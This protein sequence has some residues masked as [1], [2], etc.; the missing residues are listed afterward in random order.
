MTRLVVVYD[1]GAAQPLEIHTGLAPLG[2]VTYALPHSDHND[3]MRPLLAEFGEVVPLDEDPAERI[4]RLRPDAVLTFSERQL[5]LTSDL[6][7]A[8]GLPGHSP[9]TARALTDKY[10]QRERLRAAGVDRLRCARLSGPGDWPAAV[11]AVG[12]PAVLK[13][14]RGEGSRDTHRI[15]DAAAGGRLVDELHRRGAADLVLERYLAGRDTGPYGD[16]VSVESV[17]THGRV[18]HVAVTGKYPLLEP[19][20]ERGQF[21]PAHLDHDESA[22]VADLAGRA[23]A[24]L[25]VRTGVAHTEIKLT[26]DGPHVIEVNGRLGGQLHDL[27]LR[28][29]GP[30]LVTLAGRAALGEALDIGPFRPDGVFFQHNNPAPVLACRLVAVRG[31]PQVRGM[32][33]IDGYR[34][35]VQPGAELPGGVM[36]R[37]LDVLTGRTADHGSML[38]LVAEARRALE[39]EF[40]MGGDTVR[41]R[42]DRLDD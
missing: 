22:A 2:R 12:L 41:I 34:R 27:G 3:R 17:V 19:F 37:P 13:P 24:A 5:R 39:F 9:D 16:Y 32:A 6:A 36:T 20:R 8:L 30:D 42:S 23:V 38:E 10:L 35:F 4:R 18:G 21:W 40:A 11:A 1:A 29:G 25:G 31:V 14:V 28:A 33:G 15:L 26:P 7:A